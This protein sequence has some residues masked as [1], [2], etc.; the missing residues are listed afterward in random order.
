MFVIQQLGILSLT[1]HLSVS[2]SEF[3]G[4]FITLKTDTYIVLLFP[5]FWA[6][7]WFYTYQFNDF[8][9]Y[10]FNIRT[11][12][13][14]NLFYWHNSLKSNLTLGSHKLSDLWP[15]GGISIGPVSLA[16]TAHCQAGSSS[17][18]S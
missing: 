14:N 11:R 13:F 4:L 17:S 2:R 12:A 18:S 5:L 16:V 10:Y 9:Q 1:L 7:N 15:L 6:S 3:K 8:N